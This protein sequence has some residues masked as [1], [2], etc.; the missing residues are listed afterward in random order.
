M[1]LLSQPTEVT[2]CIF[3]HSNISQLEAPVAKWSNLA[4]DLHPLKNLSKYH[5]REMREEWSF[6]RDVS[7]EVCRI[8]GC[9][10][11]V[12]L[13]IADGFKRG[14]LD[15]GGDSVEGFIRQ[16]AHIAV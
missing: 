11:C 1:G 7:D 2:L 9:N 10:S 16:D 6:L 13:F 3:D 15:S 14:M 8:C 4:A 5:A 12:E